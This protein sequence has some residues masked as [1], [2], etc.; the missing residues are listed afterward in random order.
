[1]AAMRIV[2]VSYGRYAALLVGLFWIVFLAFSYAFLQP[3]IVAY[4]AISFLLAMNLVTF[5]YFGYDKS[6]SRGPAYRVPERVLLWL[7]F[8]GGSPA[9]GVAQSI[10]RHKTRK[11]GFRLRYF[12][13][14][15]AHVFI[16]LCGYMMRTY[17][18]LST[19]AWGAARSDGLFDFFGKV[20]GGAMDD[21][22]D[23]AANGPD[24][25]GRDSFGA[26]PALPSFVVDNRTTDGVEAVLARPSGRYGWGEDRVVGTPIRAGE[27]RTVSL[28]R[29]GDDDHCTFD[30]R[31]VVRGEAFEALGKDLCT[32]DVRFVFMEGAPF[33]IETDPAQARVHVLNIGQAYRDR[34]GLPPREYRV[35][36]SATGFYTKEEI[37]PHG[38]SAT[39]HR[40]VLDQIPPIRDCE[41]CPTMVVLPDGWYWRSSGVERHK[42]TIKA[43]AVGKHE[44]T[45]AQW[46]D[47]VRDHR[48]VG[49]P[50]TAAAPPCPRGRGIAKGRL[51]PGRGQRPVVNV[52]WDDAEHYVRWLRGKTSKPYRLL[53][54][55]EWEY[56][57]RAGTDTAYSWGD[58]IG[59]GLANC[60]LCGGKS[61]RHP[62]RVGSFHANNWGLHDMHGNVQEWVKD[63][64][65]DSYGDGPLDGSAWLS[66]DCLS[67]VVRGGS[68]ASTPLAVR[69]G[70]RRAFASGTRD[71]Y[72]GFRVARSLTP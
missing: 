43:F 5:I 14:V 42:V 2:R 59:V 18:P 29:P 6:I 15:L 44:V 47:C 52:S 58:K 36:V 9:A 17:L 64:W 30:V 20:G 38:V 39:T 61:D 16:V 56:A 67:R 32:G 55:S 10:L 23:D 13:I 4:W 66:G 60:L 19:E 27:G 41:R 53:T 70:H 1:M 54:E 72:G 33:T 65:N 62:V 71:G 21:P 31:V 51:I 28:R 50:A 34:M 25:D 48:G 57:A 35:E 26:L 8:L 12:A 11:P 24:M 3:V 68:W 22:V 40:V 49:P 7:A 37:V 69:A 63:C 46:N 45:F